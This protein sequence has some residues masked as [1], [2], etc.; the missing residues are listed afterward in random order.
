MD[1]Q[2]DRLLKRKGFVVTEVRHKWSE[3]E[4][5]HRL[6]RNSTHNWIITSMTTT[7]VNNDVNKE[8]ID[9]NTETEEDMDC[10][11]VSNDCNQSEDNIKETNT[12]TGDISLSVLR[13]RSACQLS[14]DQ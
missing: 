4:R 1:K 11:I 12:Y 2:R 3:G 5:R 10:H 8:V 14:C 6:R 13:E 9:V 7:Q